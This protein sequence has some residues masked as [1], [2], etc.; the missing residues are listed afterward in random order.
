MHLAFKTDLIWVKL[1]ENEYKTTIK[2]IANKQNICR[3]QNSNWQKSTD[4]SQLATDNLEFHQQ[5]SVSG[6]LI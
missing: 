2:F 6:S 3:L 4:N 5:S 1:I